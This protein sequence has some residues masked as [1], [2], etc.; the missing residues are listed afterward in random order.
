MPILTVT[1]VT[2]YFGAER[3][4]DDVSFAIERGEHVGLV[5]SNG[6]GKSTLL[7]V[8]AG[9]LQPDAGS[10]SRARG[11]RVAYLPQEPEFEGT[12][13][14][15]D[16]MLDVFKEAV[17][18]QE[19]LHLIEADLAEGRNDPA[20]MEEYGELQAMVERAGYDHRARIERVLTG[21]EL[22][23]DL[24]DVPVSQLSGGQRTRANLGRTLLQEVDL[25]LLDE[26]TNHLD[27]PA[28]EWLQS[29]LA[30]QA[31]AFIVVAHDRYLLDAVTQR[32]LELSNGKVTSYDAPYVRYLEL[33]R[34]RAR[35]MQL[36]YDAQQAHIARTEEFIR[37]YGA[38][39]RYKEA[40]G[41]QK[42]LDR[43]ERLERPAEESTGDLKLRGPRRTGDIVL[44]MRDL[45]VG[46]GTTPLFRLGHEVIV[47]RGEHVALIGANGTGKTTLLRTLVGEVQP[48]AGSFHWGA[49]TTL[50][51]FAQSAQGL[52]E[53]LT[54]IDQIRRTAPLDEEA[55]RSFLGRFLFTG[56]DAFKPIS[57]LS[58]GERSRVALAKLILEEPNV[59]LL[60]EPTNHLDI[61]SREA[62]QSVLAQFP[63]TILFVSHDRYL[64]D[65][66]ASQL[67]VVRDGAVRRYA[68]TYSAFSTG[69]AVALET[70]ER[71][72]AESSDGG[73]EPPGERVVHLDERAQA[74]SRRLADTAATASIQ[75]LND[76]TEEYAAIVQ[77]LGMTEEAWLQTIRRQLRAS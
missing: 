68:G 5:G 66:L 17:E 18:A 53:G 14:L 60:D 55:A 9:T 16:V 31:R 12:T 37:R 3:I 8:I 74:I 44:Q 38:G 2:Q 47:R 76:L 73:G 70:Q 49:G 43:L 42:Q 25:L 65:S 52:D 39:Q 21:L 71:A 33:R 67:W 26:P 46:Y 77:Q 4:L 30:E 62:L 51:Y 35:R 24:W 20:T 1:G 75:Q 11:V 54:V 13:P 40:R 59:L 36:E 72:P 63:G 32:T 57:A 34:E 41:R 29:Y 48:V 69:T 56:D 15:F 27:I 6:A 64:I 50:G 28:V 7:R 45:A 23:A 19:L 22:P 58:G 10:V 61:A